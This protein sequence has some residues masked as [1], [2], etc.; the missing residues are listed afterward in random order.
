MSQRYIIVAHAI[1][2]EARYEKR[3]K[4][5]LQPKSFWKSKA[6]IVNHMCVTI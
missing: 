3:K 4:V 6:F 5:E 2:R 1:A